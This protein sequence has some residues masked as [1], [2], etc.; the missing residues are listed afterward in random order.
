MI[1]K[2]TLILFSSGILFILIG[3]PFSKEVVFFLVYNL[4]VLGFL[5][6]DFIFTP[7]KKD[8]EVDRIVKDK[9]IYG[10]ENNVELNIKNLS[11]YKLNISVKDSFDER[12]DGGN[13]EKSFLNN[14]VQS[15]DTLEIKYSLKPNKRGKFTFYDV[16]IKFEGVL[17]LCARVYKFEVKSEV[18]VYPNFVFGYKYRAMIRNKD[19][20][21]K[22]VL[23][24]KSI[25]TQPASLREYVTGD[26]F[27]RINW[28]A[29]AKFNKL[30]VN[31]YDI[32]NNQNFYIMLDCG[33]TMGSIWEN[34][35]LIDWAIS[36]TAIIADIALTNKDRVGLIGFDSEIKTFVPVGNKAANAI[37]DSIY[38]V[39]ASGKTSNYKKAALFLM[40]KV[41]KR[42]LVC[43]FTNFNN[44]AELQNLLYGIE[45]ITRNHIVM[46][47][48]IE[49]PEI[50]KMQSGKVKL[51]K[52]VYDKVSADS[53]IRKKEELI[54]KLRKKGATIV[55][56]TPEDTAYKT[57]ITYLDLRAKVS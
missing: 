38:D 31:D 56:A 12:L 13:S 52:D 6:F 42:S 49:D 29:S 44:E 15:N 27:K 25:G 4:I 18:K 36:C 33:R 11:G 54:Y 24:A 55:Y 1:T 7:R 9:I 10:I 50:K 46:V 17:G 21:A 45:T 47:V 28:N 5:L 32:E 57:I 22:R 30:I 51:V 48:V 34:T 2:K 41:N 35:S 20:D 43:I 53:I 26:E 14:I 37:V 3:M 19:T 23:K 8:I 40:Q 39:E 16:Y